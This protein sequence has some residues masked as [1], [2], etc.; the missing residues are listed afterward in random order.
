MK[1]RFGS[2]YKNVVRKNLQQEICVCNIQER[3]LGVAVG[4]ITPQAPRLGGPR[5]P[6]LRI[7]RP[8]YIHR[9]KQ[10]QNTILELDCGKQ[11]ACL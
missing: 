11:A 2:S 8:S 9:K 1:L 10:A 7:F 3:P 5:V 6:D 4:A